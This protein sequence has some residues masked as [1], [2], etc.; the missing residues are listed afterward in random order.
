VQRE[1]LV[2]SVT[3]LSD[4]V[5]VA[6][7][8]ER[9]QWVRPTRE[10][11]N[12]WRQLTL[13]DLRDSEKRIVVKVG[14]VVRWELLKPIPR[15]VHREDAQVANACPRLERRLDDAE[16]LSRCQAVR[17]QDLGAFLGSSRSL[18]LFQ[19]DRIT[20]VSFSNQGKGGISARIRFRHGFVDEDYSVT[21]LGWR[22]L[23]RELLAQTGLPSVSLGPN[24]LAAQ[25]GLRIRYLA[26]GRGQAAEN[27]PPHP[28]ADRYWPFFIT[29]FTQP[30]VSSRIDYANL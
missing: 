13:R 20:C 12:G 15:D 3:R 5:C 28:V 27:I 17:E 30:P 21:D 1:L 8:D 11:Y 10:N 18:A 26:I 14:N 19:P 6:C 23:G 7:L 9:G 29:V 4:G 16:L 24:G 25:M 2:M 22:A